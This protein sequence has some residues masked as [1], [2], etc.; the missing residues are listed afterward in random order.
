[1]WVGREK[2][3]PLGGS[4]A[5]GFVHLWSMCRPAQLSFLPL[6]TAKTSPGDKCHGFQIHLPP[7]LQRKLQIQNLTT[8]TTMFPIE[9]SKCTTDHKLGSPRTVQPPFL[10][11]TQQIPLLAEL[12]TT[13]QGGRGRVVLQLCPSYKWAAQRFWRLGPNT[14]GRWG[15]S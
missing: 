11:C 7:T 6:R 10:P 14:I 12:V 3:A 13:S 5:E 1:M 8:Q 4:E 15:T 2:Q 9:S